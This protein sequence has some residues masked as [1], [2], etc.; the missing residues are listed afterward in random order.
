MLFSGPGFPEFRPTPP[1]VADS[2]VIF[3]YVRAVG[4]SVGLPVVQVYVRGPRGGGTGSLSQADGHYELRLP[5]S[6]A[7]TIF[8]DKIGFVSDRLPLMVRSGSL[9]IDAELYEYHICLD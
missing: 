2:V 7:D 3:G 8:F 6:L 1:S 4:D 5:T 9:R